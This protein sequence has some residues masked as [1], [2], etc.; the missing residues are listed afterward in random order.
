MRYMIAVVLCGLLA[1]VH[2]QLWW[3]ESSSYAYARTQTQELGRIRAGNEEIRL[4]NAALKAELKDLQESTEV[5][6]D[7]ARSELGMVKPDEVLIVYR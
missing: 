1:L 7:H 2:L 6:E 3:G 4:E 5:L